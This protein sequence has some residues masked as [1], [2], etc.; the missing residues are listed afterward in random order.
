LQLRASTHNKAIDRKR[1]VVRSVSPRNIKKACEAS[2]AL[3]FASGQ[4]A[5]GRESTICA[6][7]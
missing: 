4:F 6:I 5:A 2:N 3:L 7:L 1:L